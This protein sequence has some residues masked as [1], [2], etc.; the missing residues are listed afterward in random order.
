MPL[1]LNGWTLLNAL[2]L[3]PSQPYY[4]NLLPPKFTPKH[5]WDPWIHLIVR[6][7]IPNLYPL[8]L[9]CLIPLSRLQLTMCISALKGSPPSFRAVPLLL[10]PWSKSQ[11]RL[12]QAGVAEGNPGCPLPDGGGADTR[13]EA[14]PNLA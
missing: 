11:K 8:W 6:Q 12:E 4:A 10:A 1:L 9:L 14:R 2:S 13:L 5:W 7:Q 3:I